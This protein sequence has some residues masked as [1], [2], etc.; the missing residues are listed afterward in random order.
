MRLGK[1]KAAQ[2]LLKLGEEYGCKRKILAWIQEYM[3]EGA[4]PKYD[5]LFADRQR[6][7]KNRIPP[8]SCLRLPCTVRNSRDESQGQNQRS[9]LEK[10]TTHPSD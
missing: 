9:K 10:K 3:P 8:G 4:P 2:I 6:S 7:L 5:K 1:T